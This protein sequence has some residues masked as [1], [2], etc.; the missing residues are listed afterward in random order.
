M[1]HRSI[2]YK[3]ENA[4]DDAIDL[5]DQMLSLNPKNRPDIK[6]ILE[7]PYFTNAPEPIDII[8]PF[9]SPVGTP[10]RADSFSGHNFF[11]EPAFGGENIPNFGSSNNDDSP[12]RYMEISYSPLGRSGLMG[13][14]EGSHKKTKSLLNDGDGL[15]IEPKFSYSHGKNT[16]YK[17]PKSDY[18]FDNKESGFG[19]F[20]IS[21]I[22]DFKNQ[23]QRTKSHAVLD[24]ELTNTDT[25]FDVF[26]ERGRRN[27]EEDLPSFGSLVYDANQLSNRSKSQNV[28]ELSKM[29]GKSSSKP[30]SANK[31]SE[32][33]AKS[34]NDQSISG[35]YKG[36]DK[37]GSIPKDAPG[38]GSFGIQNAFTR[39]DKLNSN[40]QEKVKKPSI[41]DDDEL[42][43][44][45]AQNEPK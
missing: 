40:H 43:F 37:F 8:N 10:E 29:A 44:A 19:G 42:L 11:S 6:T 18:A 22:E 30:L 26:G 14:G 28:S 33:Q 12:G 45:V 17:K 7:H 41:C 35:R 27:Q 9:T 36:K 32:Y 39:G 31:E 16:Q 5:M 20:N 4:S 25:A 1:P 3:V 13:I 15:P 24:D 34:S 21:E 23:K 38:F 2:A